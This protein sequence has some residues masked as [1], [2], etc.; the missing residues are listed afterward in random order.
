MRDA[1]GA[2]RAQ[3][4]GARAGVAEMRAEERKS[5]AREK[6]VAA[7]VK[8]WEREYDRMAREKLKAKGC[9]RWATQESRCACGLESWLGSR[10]RRRSLTPPDHR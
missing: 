5:K 9:R 2:L 1:K 8:K 3:V 6:A 10:C 7:F 4:Q